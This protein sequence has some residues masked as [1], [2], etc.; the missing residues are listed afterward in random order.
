M[1]ELT[2]TVV[3]PD[4]YF[5]RSAWSAYGNPREAFF[6]ETLQNAVDAGA[7]E[8]RFTLTDSTI[9]VEDDGDGMSEEVVRPAMLTL[10]GSYKRAGSV[11][12]FGSAKEI[13][14]FAHDGYEIHTRDV[15]VRGRGIRYSLE[16]VAARA[17][18]RITVRPHA[19]FSYSLG[20]F[21]GIVREY[22]SLCDVRPKVILNG[23]VVHGLKVERV[24]ATLPWGVVCLRNLRNETRTYALIRAKGVLMFR[25]WIGECA[26]LVC[27]DIECPSTQILTSNR[28]SLTGNAQD[29][30]NAEFATLA[31]DKESYGRKRGQKS[32]IKGAHS[33][34]LLCKQSPRRMEAVVTTLREVRCRSDI[35]AE[36]ERLFAGGDV[37]REAFGQTVAHALTTLRDAGQ[38]CDAERVASLLAPADEAEA[39]A[40]DFA[41]HY[42]EFDEDSLP[43]KYHPATMATR[44][45]TLIALWRAA[46]E[47]VC[48]IAMGESG[49]IA[50]RVG[51]TF[52]EARASHEQ[53]GGVHSFLLN[54]RLGTWKLSQRKYLPTLLAF[55]AHEVVH[56]QGLQYHN[57]EYAAALTELLA[58][59]L[60]QPGCLRAVR[61]G[62]KGAAESVHTELK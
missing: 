21:L 33:F 55:A 15:L 19:M 29:L 52:E 47:E 11:G 41:I 16:T 59:V 45:Q 44:Y 40:V 2:E 46:L 25:R 34:Y 26:K 53:V 30:L 57:E 61:K 24:G 4:D 17:G 56:A 28:D 14:L 37:C 18:T 27:V 23:D 3:M 49:R 31:I 5:V 10:N 7:T 36:I 62:T 54:P 12:G 48:R 32:V 9:T 50:F 1:T 51:W 60:A 8:V 22:L 13:I 39:V 38:E 58:K 20:D 42:G 43:A 35:L 6:R